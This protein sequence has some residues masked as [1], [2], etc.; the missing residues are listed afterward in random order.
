[1]KYVLFRS[2]Q[3]YLSLSLFHYLYLDSRPKTEGLEHQTFLVFRNEGLILTQ[4][5]FKYLQGIQIPPEQAINNVGT[6]STN[7]EPY[8]SDES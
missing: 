4:T 7:A 5:W 2:Q 1:M 6:N 8:E 3:Q